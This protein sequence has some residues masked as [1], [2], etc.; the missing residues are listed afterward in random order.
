LASREITELIV[1]F[2]SVCDD[3][4]AQRRKSPS[5]VFGSGCVAANGDL[6]VQVAAKRCSRLSAQG[7]LSD[8]FAITVTYPEP[9]ARAQT[10]LF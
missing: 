6:I 9:L 3:C 10:V 8:R 7:R 2:S 1:A 5:F 4:R